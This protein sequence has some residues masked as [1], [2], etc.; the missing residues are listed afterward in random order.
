MSTPVV[1]ALTKMRLAQQRVDRTFGNEKEK[2]CKCGHQQSVHV[3]NACTA[4]GCA[5]K[6]FVP[7]TEA[8]YRIK[9]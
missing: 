7:D 6:R 4:P 8:G 2:L 5:C 9:R 1:L 3:E